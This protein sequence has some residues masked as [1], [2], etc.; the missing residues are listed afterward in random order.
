MDVQGA[1]AA[2]RGE[3]A[4]T[5][6]RSPSISAAVARWV[7][8]IQASI[9][10]PV[11]SHT[12]VA[13]RPR[14]AAGPRRSGSRARPARRG[15]R[16]SRWATASSV[17]PASSSAVAAEHGEAGPQPPRRGAVGVGE[18]VAGALH[19]VAERHAA[20]A[21][22]LAAPALHARLHEAHELVVGSAPRHCTAR[23]ASIRPRG[24]SALLARDPERRAV[25]QAQP[26]RHARRQ[27]V[28]VEPQV[29]R[30]AAT[31]RHPSRS[32]P[33]ECWR[34]TPRR[35]STRT[36]QTAVHVGASGSPRQ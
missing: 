29:E 9:T 4:R 8:R 35:S 23:I 27:L 1:A 19:Q 31:L 30:H 28:V 13:G 12:S 26:A 2:R 24:D 6:R 18:R 10:Q 17:E 16:R 3:H 14:D 21:R 5:S 33:S 7:S 25:R 15:T 20:R 11:N 22:R 36:A 34:R 32:T